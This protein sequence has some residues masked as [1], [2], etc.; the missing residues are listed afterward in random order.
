[1]QQHAERHLPEKACASDQEDIAAVVNL[2]R[3]ELHLKTYF[4]FVICHLSFVISHFSFFRK[5]PMKNVKWKME[6][7]HSMSATPIIGWCSIVICAEL[8]M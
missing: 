7:N 5:W 6:N 2:G 1:M 8:P 3:R 4:P